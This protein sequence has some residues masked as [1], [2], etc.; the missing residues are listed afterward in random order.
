VSSKKDRQ[1]ANIDEAER[2]GKMT[3]AEA[4]DERI[5]VRLSA[6]ADARRARL[7]DASNTE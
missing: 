5:L 7:Y 1:L 3:A 2:Q 6:V 4:R